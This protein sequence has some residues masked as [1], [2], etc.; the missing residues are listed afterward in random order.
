MK[1]VAGLAGFAGWAALAAL[2]VLAGGTPAQA[3]GGTTAERFA[4]LAGCWGG[5]SGGSAFRETWTVATPDLLLATG[6]T[7]EAGKPVEFEFLRIETRAGGP[8][9]VAQ[10]GGAPP[11]A[12]LLSAPDSTA[13]AAV[14]ANMQHD[15]P[16][17]IGYR[18][19]DAKNIVAWIDGGAAGSPRMEF[20]MRRVGCA[21][22]GR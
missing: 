12:F 2:V 10:P 1:R 8:A 14:F 6:S 17:R 9:Y 18:R 22:E 13:E 19:V 7:V 5:E 15:F 11:T 20:P 3:A 16:K 21:S 4:W